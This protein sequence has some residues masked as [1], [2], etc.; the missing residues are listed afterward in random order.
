MVLRTWYFVI[1]SKSL[2]FIEGLEW[3][4]LL[5]RLEG[6]NW[7]EKEHVNIWIKELVSSIPNPRLT[8]GKLMGLFKKEES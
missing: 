5:A 8:R 2:T 1:C 7:S 3:F 6:R 4:P